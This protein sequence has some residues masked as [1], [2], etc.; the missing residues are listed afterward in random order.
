MDKK[1][2]FA[3]KMEVILLSTQGFLAASEWDDEN[4][5][6]QITPNPGEAGDDEVM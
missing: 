1:I 5:N 4:D 2:Y 3:P 6:P